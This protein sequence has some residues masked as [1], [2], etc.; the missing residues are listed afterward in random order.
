MSFADTTHTCRC[1]TAALSL[2]ACAGYCCATSSSLPTLISPVL[3]HGF[4]FQSKLSFRLWMPSV[5]CAWRVASSER[6]S[7]RARCECCC[8]S[9][10]CL[11]ISPGHKGWELVLCLLK[12]CNCGRNRYPWSGWAQAELSSKL[13]WQD[14][15]SSPCTEQPLTVTGQWKWET[16]GLELTEFGRKYCCRQLQICKNENRL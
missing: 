2:A 3:A 4:L 12:G 5:Q 6:S 14:L 13:T 1:L 7:V 15:A 10:K 8:R 16:F 11:G 9:A